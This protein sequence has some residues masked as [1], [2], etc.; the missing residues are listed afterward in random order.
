MNKDI[1]KQNI[2][3]LVEKYQRVAEAGKI[4]T[5]NEIYKLYGITE[6]EIKRIKK[7]K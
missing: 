7:N 3:K 5:Y 4:K 2:S 1:I 6:E